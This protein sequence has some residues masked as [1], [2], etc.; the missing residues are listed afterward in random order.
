MLLTR[1][2]LGVALHAAPCVTLH[3]AQHVGR[4][5]VGGRNVLPQANVCVFYWFPFLFFSGS[6]SLPAH[7]KRHAMKEVLSLRKNELVTLKNEKT[8]VDSLLK[9]YG[10][11]KDLIKGDIL[12]H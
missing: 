10:R 12:K 4:V 2:H 11:V 7:E 9:L 1:G 3:I 8:Y 5:H 6:T